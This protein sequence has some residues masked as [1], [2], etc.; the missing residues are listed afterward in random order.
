FKS[1]LQAPAHPIAV[2]SLFWLYSLIFVTESR[3][4]VF[5]RSRTRTGAD[6]LFQPSPIF[7]GGTF[8]TFRYKAR[9]LQ[10]TV[11]DPEQAVLFA[12]FIGFVAP[13]AGFTGEGCTIKAAIEDSCR[14]LISYIEY[15]VA[16]GLLPFH[17]ECIRSHLR[18]LREY[19][20]FEGEWELLTIDAWGDFAWGERVDFDIVAEI[21]QVAGIVRQVGW[22]KQGQ[23]QWHIWREPSFLALS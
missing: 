1:L 3:L 7:D 14:K 16:G 19:D 21:D 22:R 17:P 2:Y 11:F 4:M 9:I 5:L 13:T 8:P 20:M 18:C 6:R 12:P 15:R 10:C 23:T